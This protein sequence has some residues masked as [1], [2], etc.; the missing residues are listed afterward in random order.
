MNS[1]IGD[2]EIRDLYSDMTIVRYSIVGDIVL[3]HCIIA[4]TLGYRECIFSLKPVFL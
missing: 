4:D 3:G 2:I 1:R